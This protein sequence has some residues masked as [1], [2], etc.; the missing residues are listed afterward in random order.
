MR[1]IETQHASRSTCFDLKTTARLVPP[2]E[3]EAEVV[4]VVPRKDRAA[5]VADLLDRV[6]RF[7]R[8]SPGGIRGDV[9]ERGSRTR[10]WVRYA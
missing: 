7:R 5:E 4:A 1:F 2:G 3:L 6:Q 8:S 10:R 9:Q